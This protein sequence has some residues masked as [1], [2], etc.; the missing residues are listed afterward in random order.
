MTRY[1]P[2]PNTL[3]RCLASLVVLLACAGPAPAN[4][5]RIDNVRFVNRP[6]AGELRVV[7]DLS[8]H[9]AWHTARNHDAAWIFLKLVYG[10]NGARHVKLLPGGHRALDVPGLAAPK[11]Q[12]DVAHDSTGFFVYPVQP[13]RGDVHWRLSV[14]L[15]PAFYNPRRDG[16]ARLEVFGVEM[17][18][19][20]E[21]PFILGD[22]DT[23]ALNFGA[24]YQ[25]GTA[26]QPDGLVQITSEEADIPVGPA[27]GQLNYRNPQPDYQGDGQGPVPAAFPKGFRAFYAMKYEITQGQYAAFLNTLSD[28]ETF[29]RFSFGGRTYFQKRGTI[30]L[31]ED[32]YVAGSPQRPLNFLS[33]DDGLAFADWAALRPMTELEFTKASR[34]P[35]PPTPG[36]FPWGTASFEALARV[37]GPDDEL[38]MENGWDESRLT[39][40]TRPVF[41]A[42]FYWVMDLAGSVWERVVTIGQPAGRAFTGSHGDGRLGARGR[43]TN[44]DWPHDYRGAE[45]H[46]YRGGGFYDQGRSIT[47]FNPYSPVAYRRFGGWAGSY[48]YRAYGFRCA[49]TAGS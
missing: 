18:Y 5:L 32:R 4:D 24:F 27:P 21:G 40:E 29:E 48:P 6:E 10:E 43:A 33:W 23:T 45:G 15:D 14:Q 19:V 34:G 17:V 47:E 11:A 2:M 13:H 16:Q 22:P 12:I 37:V 41:G 3:R 39:D 20:S 7:F 30:H 26:G 46:G 9:N 35:E 28:D 38:G 31:E 44:D 49:R 8:W 36:A 25:S 42:S 1:A